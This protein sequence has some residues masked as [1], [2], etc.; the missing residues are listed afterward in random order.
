MQ[1]EALQSEID[2]KRA[3]IEMLK[4]PSR[5][6]ASGCSAADVAAHPPPPGPPP[7]A[8]PPT[9]PPPGW[10]ATK[11]AEGKEYYYNENTGETSWSLPVS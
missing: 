5:E 6:S 9:G 8:A 10:K 2:A 11:T 3:Q 7:G 4:Q 1:V